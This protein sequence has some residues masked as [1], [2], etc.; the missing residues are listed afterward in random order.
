MPAVLQSRCDQ[1][2]TDLREPASLLRA[3]AAKAEPVQAN[4]QAQWVPSTENPT[5]HP[6]GRGMGVPF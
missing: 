2:V 6:P 3:G 4:N 5:E 1:G